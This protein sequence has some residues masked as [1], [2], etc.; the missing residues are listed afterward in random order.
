MINKNKYKCLCCN[1]IFYSYKKSRNFCSLKCYHKYRKNHQEFGNYKNAS[2][3]HNCL[4]C[5]K[6]FIVLKTEN[7]K[8]CSSKCFQNNRSLSVKIL[9]QCVICNNNFYINKG[10]LKYKGRGET[11]SVKCRQEFFK[12]GKYVNC[13]I[14]KKKI[15]KPQWVLNKSKHYFCSKKCTYKFSYYTS[16][17]ETIIAQLL[18]TL[19]IK[20]IQN[21]FIGKYNADFY[22][23]H[24]NIL[25]ECDGHY[26]HNL[27]HIIKKDKEKDKYY[28][29]KKYKVL[30]LQ[31][32]DILN[33]INKCEKKIVR[34]LQNV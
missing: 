18:K 29:S 3:I 34:F 16:N 7:R 19:K 21:E 17:L 1:K 24:K 32:K 14:C 31:E 5:N 23:K 13:E 10:D 30:R 8:Y 25:I 11:C 12:L 20:F 27:P 28:K 2:I 26:W 33:N 15:Y 4:Y 22:I 9:N 6:K